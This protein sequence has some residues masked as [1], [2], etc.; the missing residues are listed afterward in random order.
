MKWIQENF[1]KAGQSNAVR[2]FLNTV[3]YSVDVYESDI[4][5]NSLPRTEVVQRAWLDANKMWGHP[6]H[7]ICPR[8]GSLPPRIAHYLIM[9]YSDPGDVIFDPFS[10]KGT[11]PLQ[12]CMDGRYGIGNDIS[13]EA[14][15]ITKAITDPPRLSYFLKYLNRIK[16]KV[17]ENSENFNKKDIYDSNLR[18]FFEKRTLEQI[19][20]IREFL[21]EKSNWCQSDFFLAAIILGLLHGKSKLHFSI[22]CSHSYSMSPTYVKKYIERYRKEHPDSSRFK[23]E[24]K[25]VWRSISKRAELLLQEP[26]PN[27]FTTGES[28]MLDAD[29]AAEKLIRRGRGVDLIITSPPYLNAQTYAWDNWLRL[30]FLGEEY[31]EVH[32]THFHTGSKELYLDRMMKYIQKFYNVLKEDSACFIIVGDVKRN[33]QV[34]KTAAEIAK[35]INGSGIGFEIEKIM[36]DKIP[37][38]RKKLTYVTRENGIRFERILE[39]HKGEVKKRKNRIRWK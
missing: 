26:M 31:K 29:K 19:L 30:W 32:K 23:Y 22:P 16:S 7:R 12:A 21:L 20:N 25:D 1:S 11:I 2:K 27:S 5:S 13:K 38:N 34:I 18:V 17:Q 24:K 14:Y 37:K 39:L 15:V 10:G 35:K 36:T 3:G 33:G 9:K 8:T 6:L 4:K 28:Y